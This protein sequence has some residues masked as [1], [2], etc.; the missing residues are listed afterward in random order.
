MQGNAAILGRANLV[1]H[2]QKTPLR[3]VLSPCLFRTRGIIKLSDDRRACISLRS[4]HQSTQNRFVSLSLSSYLINSYCLVRP[5][6]STRARARARSLYLSLSTY[7]CIY[8]FDILVLPIITHSLFAYIHEEKIKTC[9][10]LIHVHMGL[11][12]LLLVSYY[13]KLLR[14]CLD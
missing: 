13:G 4:V 12:H 9:L 14:L 7:L 10:A 6:S 11:H 8:R 2:M 1:R 5:R 3:H